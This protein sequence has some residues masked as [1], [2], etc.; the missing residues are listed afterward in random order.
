MELLEKLL[1]DLHA[2]I[3]SEDLRVDATSLVANIEAIALAG[4]DTSDLEYSSSLLFKGDSPPSIIKFLADSSRTKDKEILSAKKN[5]LKFIALYCKVYPTLVDKFKVETLRVLIDLFKKETSGEVKACLLLPVKNLL[6]TCL[7]Q[8]SSP[9]SAMSAEELQLDLVYRVIMDELNQSPS[10]ISKGMR[11]EGLKALGLLVAVFPAEAATEQCI[12]GVL[13]LCEA[14]LQANFAKTAK[15]VD[16]SAIAGAF[17]CLDRCLSHFEDRYSNSK[18][19]WRCLLQAVMAS[20]AADTNR[21]AASAKAARLISHHAELFREL[22]GLNAE[23]SHALLAAMHSADKKALS[24]HSAAALYA[25]LG[26]I[27]AY[28]VEQLQAAAPR[29]KGDAV[30]AEAVRTVRTQYAAYMAVLEGGGAGSKEALMLAVQG[31]SAIAPAVIAICGSGTSDGK[32]LSASSAV[33][34][35]IEA[36]LHH[37]RLSEAQAGAAAATSAPTTAGGS[38]ATTAGSGSAALTSLTPFQE[39]AGEEVEATAAEDSPGLAAAG[40]GYEDL[41][42]RQRKL[43]FLAAVVS[44][45]SAASTYAGDTEF[46]LTAD[47]VAFVEECALEAVVNYSRFWSKQQAQVTQTLCTLAHALLQ[48]QKPGATSSVS[49]AAL[50]PRAALNRLLESLTAALLVRT[51]SRRPAAETLNPAQARLSEYTGGAE[52]RLLFA[53]LDLW[54]E[55]LH[56]RDRAVVA[57]LMRHYDP[58]YSEHFAQRLFDALL[59]HLLRLLGSL[60]LE[61]EVQAQAQGQAQGQQDRVVLPRNI[62]D[63]DVLLNLVAFLELLL[64]QAE[65][66]FPG[67]LAAWLPLLVDCVVPLAQ[68]L[69]LLSSL[70]RLLTAALRSAGEITLPAASAYKLKSL[71]LALQHRATTSAGDFQQEL[72]DAVLTLLL[73]APRSLLGIGDMVETLRLSLASG[74]QALLSVQLL[75]RHLLQD[76]AAVA[77]HL[78]ALLPLLDA[79]L[80]VGPAGGSAAEEGSKLFLKSQAAMAKMS[81][82]S[83]AGSAAADTNIS[84]ASQVQAA[85]LELLGR[86]GGQAQLMLAPA[87]LTVQDALVWS[88]KPCL[89]LEVPTDA[90]SAGARS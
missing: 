58:S 76:R 73:T 66:W 5:A 19:L 13:A 55:L 17:S 1:I 4:M 83:K 2:S 8:T 10:K 86:L 78:P 82:A 29:S 38:N 81:R 39:G 63:Q 11:C 31:L 68:G 52:N 88:D 59:L 71:F 44:F 48:L 84:Y 80:S 40:A 90:S 12:P 69:P 77:P 33:G 21:Y 43:L 51:V 23:Q 7:G 30:T 25:V 24:K 60:D 74:V 42:L 41:P 46:A 79:Y 16:F 64:P 14:I 67:R 35:I 65:G 26:Q 18:E 56:P 53:Y 32:A 20:T 22:I 47:V 85:V 28:V 72:L 36:A 49:P 61:Y 89:F 54:A 75:A 15:E 3:D 50:E 45:L 37:V 57:L 9:G 87:H 62:A 70:Y 34:K 6:R 27:A